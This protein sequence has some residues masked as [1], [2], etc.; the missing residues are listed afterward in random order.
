VSTQRQHSKSVVLLQE[1]FLVNET[2]EDRNNNY[3]PLYILLQINR[4][5]S[6][7]MGWIKKNERIVNLVNSWLN[8]MV[9]NAESVE[10]PYALRK[11]T[12][13]CI[14]CLV[15]KEGRFYKNDKMSRSHDHDHVVKWMCSVKY[16]IE[17]IMRYTF[18]SYCRAD[19][20]R[21]RLLSIK[22]GHLNG[23]CHCN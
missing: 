8:L 17:Q 19:Y 20:N 6:Q 7:K 5:I 11:W 2:S 9:V 16:Q 15:K 21:V 22:E 13:Y 10:I 1:S 23:C 18:I 14:L 4:D 3:I 12:I